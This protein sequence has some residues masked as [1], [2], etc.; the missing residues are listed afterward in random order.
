M[1]LHEQLTREIRTGPSGPQI[2]AFFDLDQTLFAG[3]SATAFTRD[4]LSSGRLKPRDLLDTAR[5]TLSF[6]MGSLINGAS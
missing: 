6:T 1:T 5:A 3:F 2:G 4:Q